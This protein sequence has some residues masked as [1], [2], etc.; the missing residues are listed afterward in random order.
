MI[1]PGGDRRMKQRGWVHGKGRCI[2]S[3]AAILRRRNKGI[4]RQES[5]LR[6]ISG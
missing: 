6:V 1:E 2:E 5:T 3:L 4:I